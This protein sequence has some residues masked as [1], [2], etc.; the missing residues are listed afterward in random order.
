MR[1]NDLTAEIK[2]KKF[3]LHINEE[4]ICAQRSLARL[5]IL[6]KKK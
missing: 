4:N 6:K 2:S 5:E 3:E 1:G